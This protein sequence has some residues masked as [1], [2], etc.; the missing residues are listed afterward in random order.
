MREYRDSFLKSSLRICDKS[1]VCRASIY[2]GRHY[3]FLAWQNGQFFHV[4][5]LCS[6]AGQGY[7]P[8]SFLM[9][10][11]WAPTPESSHAFHQPDSICTSFHYHP[12]DRL[13]YNLANQFFIYA[14]DP[15]P[16]ALLT[17]FILKVTYKWC[18]ATIQV[19]L[20]QVSTIYNGH[21]F[22]NILL[23]EL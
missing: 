12:T 7:N 9:T 15:P 16:Y 6:M 13:H 19:S 2:R 20:G 10:F 11:R 5:P 23:C 3:R 18:F 17:Y 1:A 22:A 14:N 21:G 8:A 4:I